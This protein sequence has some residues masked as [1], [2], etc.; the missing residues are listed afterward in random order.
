MERRVASRPLTPAPLPR[1]GE[2]R[3]GGQLD[4]GA[5][6]A[7]VLIVILLDDDRAIGELRLE[8][9]PVRCAA[10]IKG[11]DE[12]VPVG[13]VRMDRPDAPKNVTANALGF[14]R[15]VHDSAVGEHNWVQCAGDVEMAD[16]LEVGRVLVRAD[17]LVT[18]IHNE[19]L[20]GDRWIPLGR[21]EAVAIAGEDDPAAGQWARAHV[22]DAILVMR[23][24][25][26]R[27]VEVFGPVRRSG[28]GRELLICQ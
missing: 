9:E 8:V 18:I 5:E 27:R 26:L 28:I 17:A 12:W 10:R 15:A 23:F 3:S 4:V 16:L 21:T 7:V 1:R 13:A 24:A 2:G 22:E 11:T 25:R 19:E 6:A 20:Q 14:E